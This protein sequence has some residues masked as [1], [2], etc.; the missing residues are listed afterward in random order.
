MKRFGKP[1]ALIPILAGAAIAILSFMLGKAYD[2][3]GLAALGLAAGFLLAMW[4]I[5]KTGL[6]K[7]GFL[8]PILLFCFGAGAAGT[9]VLSVVLPLDGEFG[10]SPG[11]A[12]AG[13][14]IGAV[15][16]AT[17]LALEMR[18]G[19]ELHTKEGQ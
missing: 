8:V 18:V 3:P 11:M 5:G 14:A 6:I 9:I 19:K 13:A 4:G 17:G 16:I 10:E 7:K 1:T 12:L 15:L 2:A